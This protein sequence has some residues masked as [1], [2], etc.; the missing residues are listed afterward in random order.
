MTSVATV[1]PNWSKEGDVS[2]I[3]NIQHGSGVNADYLSHKPQIGIG[4][5]GLKDSA[6]GSAEAYH[7]AAQGRDSRYQLFVDKA[8]KH[9][10]HYLQAG[11]V[12][13][14]Q[15]LDEPGNPTLFLHPLV[16]ARAAA[17]DLTSHSEGLAEVDGLHQG[18]DASDVADAVS[19]TASDARDKASS[20]ADRAGDKASG[21]TSSAGDHARS[22]GRPTTL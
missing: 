8:G 18:C 12:G 6:I 16:D 17:V 22:A 14:T 10:N 13:H 15:A 19:G 9:R 2:R 20:I 3:Q 11:C 7:L 21:A 5:P 4:Y 1:K